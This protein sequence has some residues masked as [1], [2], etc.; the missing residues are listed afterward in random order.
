MMSRLKIVTPLSENFPTVR[1]RW[2]L[3]QTSQGLTEH[4]KDQPA[5]ICPD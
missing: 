1:A 2:P 5:Q 3:T 4:F